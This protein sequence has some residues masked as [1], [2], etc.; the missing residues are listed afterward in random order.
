MDCYLFG[1]VAP[2]NRLC[3]ESFDVGVDCVDF[4]LLVQQSFCQFFPLLLV[5]GLIFFVLFDHFFVLLDRDDVLLLEEVELSQQT[6]VVFFELANLGL[7]LLVSESSRFDVFVHYPFYFYNLLHYFLHFN[8][9]FNVNWLDLHL[10]LHL[11]CQLQFL[12]QRFYFFRELVNSSSALGVHLIH[13]IS[14][15]FGPQ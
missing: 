13:F 11:L 2:R 7:E 5:L 15:L 3:F 4:A 1:L 14:L 6:G 12:S 10:L 9:P 8:R